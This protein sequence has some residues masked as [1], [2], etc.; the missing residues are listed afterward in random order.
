MVK[1]NQVSMNSPLSRKCERKVMLA[2]FRVKDNE[3]SDL[4]TNVGGTAGDSTY[5]LVPFYRDGIFCV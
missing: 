4:C 5:P 1:V 3:A 2:V